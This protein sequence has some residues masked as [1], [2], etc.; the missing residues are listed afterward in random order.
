MTCVCMYVMC[1]QAERVLRLVQRYV[2]TSLVLGHRS[3]LQTALDRVQTAMPDSGL[4]LPVYTTFARGHLPG[5][6][7]LLSIVFG[8]QT[9]A[10]EDSTHPAG[11]F[12]GTY[13][14][15]AGFRADVVFEGS[16]QVVRDLAAATGQAC[17]GPLAAELGYA[18]DEVPLLLVTKRAAVVVPAAQPHLTDAVDGQAAEQA[19][20]QVRGAVAL[21]VGAPSAQEPAEE[22]EEGTQ[23]QGS[24]TRQGQGGGRRVS[25]TQVW[26]G[27]V[28]RRCGYRVAALT[29]EEWQ[30]LKNLPEAQAAKIGSLLSNSR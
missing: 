15:T 9:Q 7:T 29:H 2:L 12:Q 25:G 28:L 23:Q 17:V 21:L 19:A 22:G 11:M 14:P 3:D 4:D 5:P 16:D 10:E 8:L 27:W 18:G 13:S 6:E 20:A 24:I 1:V 30:T 26:R